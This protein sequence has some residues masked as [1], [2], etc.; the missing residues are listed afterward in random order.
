MTSRAEL[1]LSI[2]GRTD[3]YGEEQPDG[4]IRIVRKP[5]NREVL[6]DHLVGRR[7]IHVF[8]VGPQGETRC[9]GFII[10]EHTERARLALVKLKNRLGWHSFPLLIEDRY[11]EGYW[12][13]MPL[14][15]TAP[16][17]AVVKALQEA[18]DEVGPADFPIE[19]FPSQEELQRLGF[20]PDQ[21]W[22]RREIARHHSQGANNAP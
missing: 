5:L 17:W 22:V 15:R 12:A 19:I 7:S 6:Q 18:L 20:W 16:A 1:L 10:R 11:D 2:A 3:A 21:E 9:G 13:W 14:K 8:L 4:T